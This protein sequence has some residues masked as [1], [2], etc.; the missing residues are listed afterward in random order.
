MPLKICTHLVEAKS[1]IKLI[2][3]SKICTHLEVKSPR[4]VLSK[5][6]MSII[7]LRKITECFNESNMRNVKLQILSE[8]EVVMGGHNLPS[9]YEVDA[10][11]FGDFY[12]SNAKRNLIVE[13]KTRNSK[14]GYRAD[15]PLNTTQVSQKKK[16]KKTV[17][18][19][20]FFSYRIQQK[21]SEHGALLFSKRL[22]QQILVGAYSMV[23]SSCL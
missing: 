9:T 2:I 5:L 17:T 12:V 11:I 7:L 22:C 3:L 16:K 4:R 10:L 8:R 18:Q 13:I 19:R 15:I 23:E 21:E 20:Q 6:L 1:H 14:H